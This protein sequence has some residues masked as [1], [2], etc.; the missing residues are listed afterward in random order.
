MIWVSLSPLYFEYLEHFGATVTVREFLQQPDVPNLVALRHDV[1]HDL[2]LALEMAYWEHQRG[3]R[4]TY[5]LLHS[6]PYWRDARLLDKGLQLQDFG[7]EV[8]LHLNVLTEWFQGRIADVAQA[9]AQLLQTLRTGGIQVTGVSAH[10][11]RMCYEHQF[12]NGWCFSEFRHP[13]PAAAQ[14][15]MSAEDIPVADPKFQL[16]YPEN[17]HLVRPDGARFDLWSISMG[18]LGIEY[19]ASRVGWDAYFT[20]SGGNWKRSPDPLKC[21]LRTGRHQVLIHP[22]YWRGPQRIYFFLSTAR[23][24]SKWLVNLLDRA[25]PLRAQHEFMLNHRYQNGELKADKH[26]ADGFVDLVNRPEEARNLL[27]EGRAWVEG[28]PQD[29]AEANV[30][31]ERFLP[32]V[33]ELY[34]DA[35][36]VHLHRDPRD[37]VRSV[38]N[39]N[40]Y[41][42]P[43]DTRHPVMPV[44][45]WDRLSQ[46]EKACWYVRSTNETLLRA[47]EHRLAFEHAT[48]D[49]DYLIDVLTDLGIPVYPRLAEPEH[50]TVINGNYS[51]AFPAYDSW[52]EEQQALF[53]A[54]CDPVNAALGYLTHTEPPGQTPL[55]PRMGQKRTAAHPRPA[56]E[57]VAQLHFTE[58]CR[59]TL[60]RKGCVIRTTMHDTELIPTGGTHAWLLIGGGEWYRVAANHGWESSATHYFRGLLDAETGA[61]GAASLFCLQYDQNGALLGKRLLGKIRAGAAPLTFSFR[62]RSDAR[63]FNLAIYVSAAEPVDRVI[64]RHLS[65]ERVQLMM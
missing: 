2:D 6:A 22:I 3:I 37:V 36:L 10:G 53:H 60:T 7:H 43:E 16:R 13:D 23:S 8:G 18:E 40:W 11:D 63:R 58:G 14:A 21:D 42:T 56:P 38:L 54:I 52:S 61:G 35:T 62:P 41:D 64:L 45:D 19:M 55:P 4:S 49:L 9:L 32:L 30:Y 50:G 34:P 65:L 15:G 44:A 27:I 12:S 17:H 25:T 47:C 46:F 48:R 28:F 33:Q 57:P 1:D 26:T 59:L 29:Y 5:Y 24:G 39:R 51:D 20:D 31:L